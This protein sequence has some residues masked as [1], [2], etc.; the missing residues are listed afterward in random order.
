MVKKRDNRSVQ[1]DSSKIQK[2][3]ESA[4]ISVDGELTEADKE[5]AKKIADSFDGSID[6]TVED[7][8]DKV[9]QKLMSSKRKDVAKAYIL[10]RNQRTQA[11]RTDVDNVLTEYLGGNNEYWNYE[12][13]NKNPKTLATQRDYMA[14]IVSTDYSRRWLFPKEVIKAHDEGIIHIHDMDYAAENAMTN[15]ALLNLE[16]MLQNGTVVNG[17]KID[18]P[19]RFITACTIATQILLGVTSSQYGGISVTLSH[20]APFVRDSYNVFYKKYINYGLTED[21]AKEFAEKDLQKEIEDGV[22]TFNYQVNSMTNANGQSPFLSV[23]MYI[24]ENPEYEKETVMLIKEFLKQRIQGLKNEKGVYV[25]QAFP[26]LL[27]ILDENNTYEDSKYFWLTVLA[28]KCTAKRLVPDYISA[29]KMRELKQGDVFPCM[30]C[31][32]FLMP[33][34]DKTG[35]SKYYGRFNEGVVTINLPDVALS[36]KGDFNEFWK[37]FDER[38]ELCH[39]ALKVKH[40]RLENVTSDVAPILWQYGAYARLPKHT[41]IAPLLHNNYSSISLGYAGLYECVKYMTGHSHSD[42]G[43]GHDF[44][45]QVMKHLKDKAD[46]WQK[47][48]N[49]GYSPYGAPIESATYKFAKCLKKRFGDDIFVKIDGH[50]R[51]YITNSVH[52][53]VFENIDPF[54]K[55]DIEAEFQPYSTGGYISYIECANM[56]NNIQAVIKVIQHIYKNCMYAELNTKSDYCSKCGYDGEIEIVDNNGYLDWR[57]PQCGNTDH[58]TLHVVRRVCGYLSSNFFNQGRT[59]EIKDRV[60]HLDN[61]EETEL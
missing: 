34:K 17:V 1:F 46:E 9:E 2:A 19:H 22:Q 11:R 32:S 59:N 23:F 52:I 35:K 61:K 60:I 38:L 50:D 57:C 49:V 28:A 4:C 24:S 48:E 53:P 43:E 47:T 27:Y 18:K 58:D 40:K 29:K 21:K 6:T 31:R 14:G 54:T 5:L 20:L 45:I 55:L 13:S 42:D 7:I 56:T 25:T 26:K 15:C 41:S 51:N 10:Y 44:A 12:N 8:Q 16:D 39:K 37:I 30:G 3:I 36:S 33:Y